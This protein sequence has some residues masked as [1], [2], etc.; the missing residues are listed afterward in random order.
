ATI[1]DTAS[2]ATFT[3]LGAARH[4][5]LPEAR[6]RGLAGAPPAAVYVSDQAHSAADKAVI[7][8]GLGLDSLRRI[9][10]DEQFRMDPGALASAMAQDAAKGIRPMAVV[11]TVGTTA[12]V[13]VDPL[14][15]IAG[16]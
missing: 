14:P 9:P 15:A 11:A 8:L 2:S 10:S 16:A 6:A 7:A 3:A 13:A 1:H 12:A 4:R 5:C